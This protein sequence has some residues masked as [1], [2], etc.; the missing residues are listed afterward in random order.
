MHEPEDI[1]AKAEADFKARLS[2]RQV[3]RF[4]ATTLKQV[5]MQLRILQDDQDRLK[6]MVNLNR[7][8]RFIMAFEQFADVCQDLDIGTSSFHGYIW[9]PCYSILQASLV[10]L[11][12][13]IF[14][15]VFSQEC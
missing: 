5:K 12:R 6:T 15:Y 10:T 13:S 14:A 2:P 11:S 4:T 3:E 8:H 1:F 9:G 7:I